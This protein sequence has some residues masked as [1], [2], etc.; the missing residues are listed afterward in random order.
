MGNPKTLKSVKHGGILC[1]VRLV[2]NKGVVFSLGV[3]NVFR[4]RCKKKQPCTRFGN[5]VVH[6]MECIS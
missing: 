4:D 2:K 5:C 6:G 3:R 1:H